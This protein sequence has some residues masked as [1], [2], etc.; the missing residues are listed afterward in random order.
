MIYKRRL[1]DFIKED[2][3]K[4]MVIIGGPRQVGKTTLSKSLF[5]KNMNYLNWDYPEDRQKILSHQI[6]L[7]KE[8]LI[9]DEIHKYKNWRSLIKGYYDV[10]KEYN[11]F[12]VTGSA[13]LD[14]FRKG[15]DSLLGR[16]HYYRLHP[17]S[18]NELQFIKEPSTLDDLLEFGG[19]PEPLIMKDKRELKRW[20]NERVVR[21]ISDDVRDL[22]TV[23][24]ISMIELL[25][26]ELPKKVG[27]P[28]SYESL[29]EDLQV[30][31][32][33]VVKWITIL[34]SLY[35]SFRIAPY[36]APR[37]RAVKKENKLYLWDW[38][39]IED[40]GIRFENMVASQLLKYCHFQE[41][42]NGERMELR[43]IRDT[44]K[45]EID[46]VVLKKEKP[47]FAVE[48]KTGDK[49]RSPWIQ[50]YKERTDIPRFYQVHMGANTYGNEETDG[51]VIPFSDFCK[52]LDMP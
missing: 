44:D 7:D 34:D 47:L 32:Q 23:K 10:H 11:K 9:F 46:F 22:S 5:E 48:C 1:S 17:F 13:R 8:L 16:Y 6:N 20:Q 39:V 52:E 18:Y 51:K 12:L 50:Y 40:K 28:L 31:H 24:D 30:S 45:R 19:F 25:A 35:Y 33:T 38:S 3:D 42:Y 41:D 27:S 2:L 37:I 14:H 4:K 29:K 36:G 15:G 26:R 49:K 21:I 43:F